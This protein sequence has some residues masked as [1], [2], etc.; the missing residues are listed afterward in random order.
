[1]ASS[2]RA[3]QDVAPWFDWISVSDAELPPGSTVRCHMLGD[4][5]CLRLLW[6]GTWTAQTADGEQVFEP[7]EDG[8]TLYFGPQS[9]AMPISVTGSFRVITI[10]LV[11]GAVPTLGAPSQGVCGD[12]IAVQDDWFGGG[13]LNRRIPLERGYDH[14]I[15]AV[16]EE[17]RRFLA[18]TGRR[19]PEA[20]SRS[21]ERECLASPDF[22]ISDFARAHG[23]SSRTL[24]RRI[25]RD[26]GASPKFVQRRA[27]ALDMTAMLLGVARSEEEPEMRH[28]YFD[29]SH[30]IR[31]MRRF[32]GMSPSALSNEAHPLLR[33]NVEIRQH[34]RI[35]ALEEIEMIERAGGVPWR[36]PTS[37]P[38]RGTD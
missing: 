9:R 27:R 8:L 13:A 11:T 2:R 31:E 25:A 21:F 17:L 28:R 12:R 22:V 15:E 19:P 18:T 10:N 29:Q 33:L 26:F 5:A 34:R 35:R 20:L 7:G 6:G 4:Q 1:M 3:A 36:D 37:E 24:E 32:L 38:D 16:E 14:W 23:V 30:L